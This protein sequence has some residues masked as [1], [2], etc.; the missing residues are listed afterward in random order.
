M[1]CRYS[2]AYK[3]YW[4]RKEE[5]ACYVQE[6]LGLLEMLQLTCIYIRNHHLWN[7]CHKKQKECLLF[8]GCQTSSSRGVRRASILPARR[9]TDS[10]L[11]S[12]EIVLR[13][14]MPLNITQQ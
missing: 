9:S 13:P 2:W 12:G 10:W 1:G 6:M 11:S 14:L 3:R 4:D 7:Q 5:N 8:P